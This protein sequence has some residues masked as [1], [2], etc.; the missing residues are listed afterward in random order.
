MLSYTHN[1]TSKII[2]VYHTPYKNK[3]KV[4]YLNKCNGVET[5]D[6][7][8][9]ELLLLKFGFV[10]TRR[11]YQ[12][13][14]LKDELSCEDNMLEK[15]F[16]NGVFLPFLPL[17]LGSGERVVHYIFGKSGVGKSTMAK[18]LSYYFQKFMK[19]YIISPVKDD[20]Y[21]GKHLDIDDLVEV[22][23]NN[24]FMNKMKEYE[25]AKIKFKY[26]KQEIEDP[27][28]LCQMEM[29]LNEMKPKIKTKLEVFKTTEKYKNKI[30]K[31]NTLWIYDD[32][33]AC[34]DKSK[35]QFLMESQ[36]LTGRHDNISLIILNH[37]A[38]NAMK[39]R[40]I[41]N[42]AHIFTFFKP[43]NRYT[44][45]FLA[46]YL[47]VEQMKTRQIKKIL[48]VQ[49]EYAW[50]SFYTESNIILSKDKVYHLKDE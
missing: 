48:D 4:V 1:D 27:D 23:E 30:G 13:K 24:N 46:E 6:E 38:N 37:Q 7:H 31:G 8:N 22:D 39:T 12:Q 32:N 25:N 17:S 40:N 29:A 43:Y 41:I 45:Y 16:K 44:K 47:L 35:L 21:Y 49:D 5:D 3:S 28:I 26:K 36:L 9:R 20:G 14:D 50:C 33:E 2:G 18:N 15:P 11:K 19:V 34:G 42:E 10:K